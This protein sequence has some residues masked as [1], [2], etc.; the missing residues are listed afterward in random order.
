MSTRM[1]ANQTA[2]LHS[3]SYLTQIIFFADVNVPVTI[4]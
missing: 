1:P 4:L 3:G 2:N